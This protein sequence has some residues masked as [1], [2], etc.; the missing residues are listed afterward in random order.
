MRLLEHTL[1]EWRTL[2]T[3]LCDTAAKRNSLERS[4]WKTLYCAAGI[5]ALSVAG[6]IPIQV[7]IFLIWPPPTTVIEY[8]RVFQSNALLGLV[9]L[10]LLLLLDQILI[11]VVIL[12]LYVALRRTDESL[13][14]LGTTAG[15]VGALL[16][17]VSRE[18]TISMWLLSQ[19]YSATTSETARAALVAAGQTLL[20]TYGGTAFSF[21]YFLS[22]LAMLILSVVML[23]G[24]LFG[25]LTGWIGV[26]AGV[27]GLV[28]ASFGTLG[29]ALSL[30]SLLPLAM[31]LALVGRRC[32]WLASDAV[33]DTPAH[34]C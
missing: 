8:F 9:N 1:V 24:K 29:L 28:P 5:A 20:T 19:Q 17:I 25:R 13:T 26:A 3:A 7:A 10:D 11:I 2:E 12:G 32:L 15:L 6:L 4:R 27:T 18:A 31:W 23:R 16:F 22:G 30:V 34:Q 14:L 21:G 33:R